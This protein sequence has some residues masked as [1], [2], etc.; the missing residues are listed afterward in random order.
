MNRV[1]I[2]GMGVV[3][4]NAVGLSDFEQALREG[5][6][7][8]AFQE[9]LARL[10]FGCQVAGIPPVTEAQQAAYF[11]DLQRKAMQGTGLLYGTIA[12]MEAWQHAGLP[13]PS[14]EEDCDIDSGCIFGGGHC[15]IEVVRE[16]I[17]KVDDFNV[18]RIGSTLVQQTMESAVS[19]YLGGFLGLGN[20]VSSNSAACSTGTEAILMGMDRI[21]YGRAKRMLVGSCNSSGP[22]IWAGFDSMRVLTRKN[23]GNPTAASRPMSA[24]ASGFAPGS[25]AGALV[26]ESLDSALARGATIYAEVLGGFIN[27]GGQR[28]G[29]S[30]TAPNI[31]GIERCIQGALLDAGIQAAQID[32][33]SGHLTATMGDPGEVAAWVRALGRAKTDFPFINSLKSMIG[34]CLSAA[35]A[36]ESVATVLQL[37][38]G[39]LHPSL[40]CEDLHPE[41]AELIDPSCIPNSILENKDLKIMA[42]ASFGFGDVNSVVIFGTGYRV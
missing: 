1:V 36:I 29:G 8:I 37:Q 3:A 12:G 28:K 42:K 31:D 17:Y 26:L 5:R 18:K 6:S 19:A 16:G 32:A 10:K 30:M 9:E 34:H 38:K 27:S 2:T 4:P 22:Y 25:G 40:N 15:G 7:G 14:K 23:N 21:R 41:I 35:G 39:F 11:T 20:Q 33:I 13:I 24:T